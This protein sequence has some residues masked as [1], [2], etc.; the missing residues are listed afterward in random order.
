MGKLAWFRKHR[1]SLSAPYFSEDQEL[2]LR[3]YRESRFGTIDQVLFAYRIRSKVNWRKLTNT[4]KTVLR[5]Q[6]RHFME[7]DQWHFMLLSILTFVGRVTGDL[8]NFVRRLFFPKQ[9][10]VV[11]SVISSQW[12]VVLDSLAD[13]PKRP[14]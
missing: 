14:R 10:N 3:T 2:L 12:L 11:A 6:L 8:L 1:Y 9:R 13:K 4:R 5:I 7:T